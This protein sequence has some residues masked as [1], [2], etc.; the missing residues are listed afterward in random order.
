MKIGIELKVQGLEPK[1]TSYEAAFPTLTFE[2]PKLTYMRTMEDAKELF[3]KGNTQFKK[4]LE[5]FL[6]DGYVTEHA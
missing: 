2:V 1:E 5:F 4:S 3:K 6:L